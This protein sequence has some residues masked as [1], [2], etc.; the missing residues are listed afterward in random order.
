[1]RNTDAVRLDGFTD[2]LD[3][4]GALLHGLSHAWANRIAS[5]AS[6]LDLMS[7]GEKE[8][9]AEVFLPI[10]ID[11][12][13]RL[14][15]GMRLLVPRDEAPGAMELSPFVRDCLG[16]HSLHGRAYAQQS[17]LVVTG[18][19]LPVRIASCELT[20]VLLLLIEQSSAQQREANETRVVFTL[21]CE[22][23]TVSLQCGGVRQISAYMNAVAAECGAQLTLT[24]AGVSLTLPTLLALRGR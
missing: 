18:E 1:M 11:K 19:E 10:E 4:S 7:F 14:T 8:F 2:W 5:L 9:G 23:L 20:R 13:V 3:L 24:D 16:L 21:V 15:Q 17:E 6:Y 22:A 12:F